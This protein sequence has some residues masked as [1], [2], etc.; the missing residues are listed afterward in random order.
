MPTRTIVLYP[1]DP[2]TQTAEP[3]TDFGAAAASLVKDMIETMHASDGVG[4]AAPQI[5]VAQRLF[6][7]CE[8]DGPEMALFNPE[9]VEADGREM[10]EEGCLSL[11]EVYTEVPRA[12]YVKVT[13]QDADGNQHELEARDFLARIMQ[14]EYDHLNGVIFLDRADILTRQ[15]KL[16]EWDEVR[17]RL[18]LADAASD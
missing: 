9:I 11:P 15:S 17:Q 1:D 7:C 2:L 13:Y 12:T 3:Y 5:G 14:H 10:G 18:S 8:P 4:L 6:V 16:A